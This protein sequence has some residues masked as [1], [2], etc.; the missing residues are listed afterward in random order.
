MLAAVIIR[1]ILSQHNQCVIFVVVVAKTTTTKTNKQNKN[2]NPVKSE[3]RAKYL[4]ER[5]PRWKLS[6]PKVVEPTN[7][8]NQNNTNR[9]PTH[10][11]RRSKKNKKTNKQ[12]SH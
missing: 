3:E 1:K 4:S 12:K 5:V 11:Q 2:K 6:R 7:N 8:N 9:T 10:P